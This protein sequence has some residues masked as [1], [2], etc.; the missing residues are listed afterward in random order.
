MV[1]I[2]INNGILFQVL[3]PILIGGD[4]LTEERITNVQRAYLDGENCYE[5]LQ[6]LQPKFE[7]WHLKKT[8]YQVTFFNRNILNSN[9]FLKVKKSFVHCHL[10][11]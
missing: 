5:R 9:F 10:K 11:L 7:D 2:I 8:L 6:G 3:S 4:Q 1:I